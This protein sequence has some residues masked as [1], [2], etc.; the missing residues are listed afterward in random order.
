MNTII[1]KQILGYHIARHQVAWQE[2]GGV[3]C[4]SHGVND[5]S[6]NMITALW[7]N[8]PCKLHVVARAEMIPSAFSV[9][10]TW[11]REDDDVLLNAGDNLLMCIPR[12]AYDKLV[13]CEA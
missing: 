11:S 1:D 2:C 8:V 4:I 10:A 12:Y 6:Y 13:R 9:L 7:D 3:M 5:S